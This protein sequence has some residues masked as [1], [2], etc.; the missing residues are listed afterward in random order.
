MAPSKGD[1]SELPGYNDFEST[2]K[3]G[4]AMADTVLIGRGDTIMDIPRRD[5]E[6]ELS[7]APEG[8]SRRLEFMS[9]DHRRIL[10]AKR[11]LLVRRTC[12][13]LPIDG[14]SAQWNV[15]FAWPDLLLDADSSG[16]TFRRMKAGT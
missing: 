11:F 3:P 16:R 12:K 8:I 14:S 2:A 15:S 9:D 10:T 1:A 5:W 7:S 13:G 4:G 6:K